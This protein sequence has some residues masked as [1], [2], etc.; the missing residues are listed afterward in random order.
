MHIRHS[1][2]KVTAILVVGFLMGGATYGVVEVAGTAGA[3]GPQPPATGVS[4]AQ[5]VGENAWAESVAGITNKG[6]TPIPVSSIPA[7][8]TLII[9]GIE[10]SNLGVVCHMAGKFHGNAVNYYFSQTG[11][12]G[13]ESGLQWPLDSTGPASATCKEGSTV[14]TVT[15]YLAP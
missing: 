3:A 6:S 7:G 8:D 12:N 5:Y 9:T 10:A 11:T 1:R 14:I 15:G 2:M 13:Q 4:S